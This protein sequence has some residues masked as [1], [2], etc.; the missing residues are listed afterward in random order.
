MNLFGEQSDLE[1]AM[2]ISILFVGTQGWSYSSWVG[3]FY[4]EGTSAGGYL[5]EYA[6]HFPTVELDTTFYAIPK[7]SL[8]DHWDWSTPEGFIFSA[9]FSKIITHEKKLIDCDRE[10]SNFLMTLSRLDQKL[11]PLVLQFDRASASPAL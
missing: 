10:A 4:P 8:V 7:P 5:A 11:G 1:L 2:N 9:K 6:R 3:P